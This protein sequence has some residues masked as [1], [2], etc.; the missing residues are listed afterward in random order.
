MP[1]SLPV[2]ATSISI[3]AGLAPG[4]T[5]I[6]R[7]S[8]H[9][10]AFSAAKRSVPPPAGTRS[11]APSGSPSRLS[12]L[13][14][15]QREASG[16]RALRAKLGTQAAID[17]HDPERSQ[18]IV[19]HDGRR[20]RATRREPPRRQPPQVRVL[21]GFVA[22]GREAEFGEALERGG[23]RGLGGAERRPR[24]I[25]GFAISGDGLGQHRVHATC[26]SWRTQS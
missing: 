11:S 4:A 7:T 20:V 17:D 15:A 10:A 16:W 2:V 25:E 26:A 21:P 6:T 14:R 19:E 12:G 18:R 8:G 3:G 24:S 9:R 1:A 22:R 5:S 13:E 23:A